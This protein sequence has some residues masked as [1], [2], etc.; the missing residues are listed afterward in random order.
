MRRGETRRVGVRAVVAL[1]LG[2]G[3]SLLPLQQAGPG[4]GGSPPAGP[5]TEPGREPAP[6][7][8]L[9]PRGALSQESAPAAR[10]NRAPVPDPE[11]PLALDATSDQP[12]LD[13]GEHLDADGL[14]PP[15]QEE[16]A[17]P[18]LDLG[19]AIDADDPLAYALVTPS[20]SP[21]REIGT[22]LDA[23]TPEMTPL[24]ESGTLGRRGDVATEGA[25]HSGPAQPPPSV[26]IG[27][28][29][30]AGAPRSRGERRQITIA[31]GR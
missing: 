17:Q 27:E 3:A 10:A 19:P 2:L 11:W 31:P 24:T 9:A 4:K 5:D 22:P 16:G 25:A 29:L 20:R 13:V 8:T 28:A 23:D 1:V 18:A 6:P 21:P 14:D 26:E 12:P 7:A 30:D 15:L